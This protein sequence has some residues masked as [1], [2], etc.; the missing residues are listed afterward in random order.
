MSTEKRRGEAKPE[1]GPRDRALNRLNGLLG[2]TALAAVFA[3]YAGTPMRVAWAQVSRSQSRP[4]IVF[5]L[6]DNLGY[7]EVGV[8]GGGITRGGS[9]ATLKTGS[10]EAA[11]GTGAARSL[12]R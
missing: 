12:D 1:V 10:P 7:G 6:M 11:R 3:L 4:N 2:V 9:V 8:Y 5:I